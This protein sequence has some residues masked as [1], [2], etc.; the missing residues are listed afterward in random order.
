MSQSEKEVLAWFQLCAGPRPQAYL[1]V[2]SF[3]KSVSSAVQNDSPLIQPGARSTEVF[4]LALRQLTSGGKQRYCT[5]SHQAMPAGHGDVPF[6]GWVVAQLGTPNYS[7]A[8]ARD[9]VAYRALRF[10]T[11]HRHSDG[12]TTRNESTPLVFKDDVLI[13]WGDE[14]LV[15]IR[16]SRSPEPGKAHISSLWPRM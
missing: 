4:K 16:K 8:V 3:K 10:R 2:P 14:V 13:G 12:E 11:L 15:S 9:G 5:S 1:S 7:E 6:S